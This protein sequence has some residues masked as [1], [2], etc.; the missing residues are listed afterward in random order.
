MS[1]TDAIKAL[2]T[3]QMTAVDYAKALLQKA[4]AVTCL[5][6]IQ[7]I[8]ATQVLAEAAAI[9]AKKAAGQDTGPLCGLP[10]GVKDSID[11]AGYKTSA[12]NKAMKDLLPPRSAPLID[13]WKAKNGIIF[14]KTRLHELSAGGTNVN[15][16]FGAV[17]NPYN[18]TRH[19]GGSSGGSGVAVATGIVPAAL[20]EDTGGSCRMPASA[21]GVVGFRPTINCYNASDGL[22]PATYTRDTIGMMARSI[23]DLVLLDSIVRVQGAAATGVYSKCLA[24]ITPVDLKTVRIGMAMN[25][26]QDLDAS[27]VAGAYGAM[28]NLQQAGVT[29]VPVDVTQLINK[30]VLSTAPNA[31]EGPRELARYLYTHGYPINILDVYNSI[32]NSVPGGLKSRSLGN[33]Q[34][35]LAASKD[36]QDWIDFLANVRPAY[37]KA[38][39]NVYSDY[40]ISALAYPTYRT[41]PQPINAV[42]PNVPINGTWGLGGASHSSIDAQ[43]TQSVITFPIGYTTDGMPADMQLAYAPG[44]DGALL[45]L[46]LAVEPLFAGSVQPPPATPEC[47]GCS[48]F[49]GQNPVTYNVSSQ[50]QAGLTGPLVAQPK[51]TDVT[52]YYSLTFKG[53]CSPFLQAYGQ[54]AA[55]SA[56]FTQTV[57]VGNI[58]ML[59]P[60]GASSPVSG[61][62]NMV[63]SSSV[64][65]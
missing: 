35:P 60:D 64:S 51:P 17:L 14:A 4:D 5:N 47:T 6:A 58:S 9:D 27:V 18:N 13:T 29:V 49:I 36:G 38:W 42:E 1:A 15:A 30:A 45:S 63:V 20:C 40:N 39:S 59:N 21:N 52:S 2:C 26:F 31:F 22:V 10:L 28:Q 43:A 23:S 61:I 37:L 62:A 7:E 3:G 56:A 48:H 46:A 16:Y 33:L 65:G 32:A 53:T 24:P 54:P 19:V 25:W 11:V 57:P 34:V 44:S 12:G 8:N 50:P 55:N 41:T